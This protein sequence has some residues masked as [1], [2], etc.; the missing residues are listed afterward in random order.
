MQALEGIRKSIRTAEDLRS[1]VKTMKGVAGANIRHFERAVESLAEYARTVE[2]GLQALLADEPER[3]LGRAD[4]RDDGGCLGAV[5]FGSDQ[6]MCGRFN[7]Q[8]AEHAAGGIRQ[9]AGGAGPAAVLVVGARAAA[10]LEMEGLAAAEQV[11]PAT[12]LAGIAPVVQ[13][14]LARVEGWRA[15]GRAGRIVLYY[16]ES[17][18]GAA[19]RPRTERLWPVDLAWL[20]GLRGRE[21][22]SRRLPVHTLE[23]GGLFSSLIRE[24]LYI[25]LF[26]AAAESLASENA[27]RLASMQAAERNI[28]DRLVALGAHYRTSRQEAITEELLDIVAGFEALSPAR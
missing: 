2:L 7:V 12:S 13:E 19:Y 23:W 9:A 27:S 24:H 20:H 4:G 16:S 18:G 22:P 11:A 8:I 3:L 10:L 21:W 15:A 6:G 5:V 17:L 25:G 14:I 28:E 1:V 26:R